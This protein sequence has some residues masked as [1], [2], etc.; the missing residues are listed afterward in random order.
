MSPLFSFRVSSIFEGEENNST[1]WFDVSIPP[2]FGKSAQQ[3]IG[4]E[5]ETNTTI[6]LNF[7]DSVNNN[8]CKVS[9]RINK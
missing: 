1:S 6:V 7:Q 9:N 4:I 5:K 2:D 8:Y 3:T